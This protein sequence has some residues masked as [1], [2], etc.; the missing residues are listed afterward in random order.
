[1][2]FDPIQEYLDKVGS[3]TPSTIP[4]LH[5]AS[6]SKTSVFS[7]STVSRR[8]YYEDYKMRALNLNGPGEMG[9]PVT[10]GPDE[11]EATE[12]AIDKY[13]INTVVSDRVSLERHLADHRSTG[14]KNMRYEKKLPAAS[15]ILLFSNE[16]KS[17]VLRT[18]HSIVNRSPAELL[19]EV[20]LVDDASTHAD[21]GLPLEEYIASTWPEGFVKILRLRKRHG[22][23]KGRNAGARMA[24][25]E[26]IVVMDAHV[27][28]TDGWLEPLL[29]RIKH[30]RRELVIPL[31][32]MISP[33][34]LEYIQLSEDAL[35]TT[36][37]WNLEFTWIRLPRPLDR[38]TSSTQPIRSPTMIGCVFA[39]DRNYFFQLGGFDEGMDVW[40]GENI[41]LPIRVWLCGGA[42]NIIPC[43]RVGHVYRVKPSWNWKNGNYGYGKNLVRLAEVW[44]E[45]Y[46]S[47]VYLYRPDLKEINAGNLTN[48]LRLKNKLNCKKFKWFLKNVVPF[49]YVTTEHSTAYGQI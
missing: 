34:T 41:E 1:M 8:P 29:S 47:L 48:Q 31:V 14:C 26:V 2:A 35:V 27:E 36:F 20:I 22:L 39:M 19:A 42:V 25:G 40:G 9:K 24:S 38:R 32:P 23:M 3:F 10:S 7:P 33:I 21:L 46:K 28:V 4:P 11:R 43:S 5:K 13:G 44:F 15:C 12:N 37:L 6:R 49:Q 30:N 17:L 16:A 18:V 45:D